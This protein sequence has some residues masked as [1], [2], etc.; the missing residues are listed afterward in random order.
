M[1]QCCCRGAKLCDIPAVGVGMRPM[2]TSLL[3]ARRGWRRRS[4]HTR[5]I[6]PRLRQPRLLL[7]LLRLLLLLPTLPVL[8]RVLLRVA[9]WA[10]A[11]Q[12]VSAAAMRRSAACPRSQ[13]AATAAL[14]RRSIPGR[15]PTR[16]CMPLPP[17]QPSTAQTRRR[18]GTP[19]APFKTGRPVFTTLQ[20]G[21]TGRPI[22]I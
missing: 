5:R 14:R 10:R 12:I 9:L 18:S 7:L 11:A 8:L 15:W 19:P 13:A 1:M 2:A 3:G 4:G 21:K 20:L 16:S 22:L 6:L 17:T